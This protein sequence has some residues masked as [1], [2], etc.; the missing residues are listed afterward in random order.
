MKPGIKSTEFWLTLLAQISGIVLLFLG[1][2][3][4]DSPFIGYIG[5]LLSILPAPAY[6]V[7]RSGVKK[8]EN[9]AAALLSFKD[10]S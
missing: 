3:K 2:L 5:G 4:P 6:A 9:E 7:A 1:S 10:P 8:S